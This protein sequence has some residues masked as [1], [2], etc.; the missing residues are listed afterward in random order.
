VTG[1]NR[2]RSSR[3]DSAPAVTHVQTASSKHTEGSGRQ[4]GD[5]A[6]EDGGA[7]ADRVGDRPE[8]RSANRSGAHKLNRLYREYPPCHVRLGTD[9]G[10]GG[11]RR[12]VRDAGSSDH[13]RHREGKG[14]IGNS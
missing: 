13:S 9:L 11:R 6:D 4:G 3:N 2:G 5:P 14:G 12:H 7:G 10:E 8:D 1:D